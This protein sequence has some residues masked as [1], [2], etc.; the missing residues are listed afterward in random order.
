MPIETREQFSSQRSIFN[1]L[2]RCTAN[3]MELL[4][5]CYV[6]VTKRENGVNQLSTVK[7]FGDIRLFILKMSR[8]LILTYCLVG[9]FAVSVDK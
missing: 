7:L 3:V 5:Q 9:S 6:V 1:S 8:K 2:Q 4:T